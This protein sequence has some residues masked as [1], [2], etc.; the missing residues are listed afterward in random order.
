MIR[1]KVIRYDLGGNAGSIGALKHLR[2]RSLSGNKKIKKLPDSICKL[3]NLQ[4]L[5][6]DRCSE[7]EELSRDISNLVSLRTL[8]VTTKQTYFPENG[9]GR[10]RSL[11]LLVN[12][13]C[14][15]LRSLPNDMRFCTTSCTL[16]IDQCEQPDLAS[17]PNQVMK[18]SLDTLMANVIPHM[19]ALPRWLQGA[20]Q[21]LQL[22]HIKG[23]P[24]LVAL[25][26]W[27]PNLTSLQTLGIVGCP[28]LLSLPEGMQRLTCLTHLGISDCKTLEERCK[29]EVGEDWPKIAHV[30]NIYTSLEDDD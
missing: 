12:Y 21:T 5:L 9:V 20:A 27:L 19:A 22:L 24:E 23:C 7:L 25:P 29:R 28:K 11:Q 26:E 1:T 3:Q 4:T 13:G 17:G 15:N 14:R 10:L 8:F 30:P 6:L 18:S 16:A 2:Y